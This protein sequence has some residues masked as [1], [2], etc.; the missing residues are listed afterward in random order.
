M[1][2]RT[3][4]VRAASAISAGAVFMGANTYI[5]NAPNFMVYAMARDAGV[6]M[7]GFFGYMLWSGGI[8]L[9]LFAAWLGLSGVWIAIVVIAW[10]AAIVAFWLACRQ[11]PSLRRAVAMRKPLRLSPKRL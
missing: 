10:A 1:E 6:K 11:P 7:P 4:P 5:G 3:A 2:A 8:L 9:P